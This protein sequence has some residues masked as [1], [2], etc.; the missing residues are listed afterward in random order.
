MRQSANIT[1]AGMLAALAVSSTIAQ[2]A[3]PAGI[4]PGTAEQAPGM[5]AANEPNTQDR[6]F[7]Q[8]VGAGGIAEVDMGK[9]ADGKAHSAAVKAFG[10]RMVQDH[11]ESN[12]Q[13]ALLAK[14]SGIAMP[15]EPGDDN[16]AMRR[17]LE[18]ADGAAFDLLYLRGQL[19]DH[20]KTITL[21]EWEIS[22]GQDA[23]LQRFASKTLPVVMQHLE[24]VQAL[25][26][27]ATGAAPQGLAATR[28]NF[29]PADPKAAR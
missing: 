6:L 28:D 7:V 11:S 1:I 17:E 12:D 10:R 21:L 9:L 2:E 8:L 29:R 13:L 3:N 14:Q 26:A 22:A 27:E 23:T 15:S 4:K 20:Q 5:P 19:V 18:A 16:E 25:L 24:M